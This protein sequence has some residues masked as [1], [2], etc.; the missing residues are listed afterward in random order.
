[1]T[2]THAKADEPSL[3][4]RTARG[5]SYLMVQ[6]A[7]SRVVMFVSQIFLG[8]ILFPEDFGLS[9]LAGTIS[10]VAWSI[11]GFGVDDVLLQRG[12]TMPKWE[13]TIFFLGVSIGTT[14]ALIVLALAPVIAWLYGHQEIMLLLCLSSL[15]LFIAG[16]ETVPMVKVRAAFDFKFLAGLNAFNVVLGQALAILFALSGFGPYSFFLPLPIQILVRVGLL[17]M[18]ARP[19][20]EGR[21]SWARA[22]LALSS[23]SKVL[24]VRFSDAVTGEAD[25]FVLGFFAATNI[26]G[27]YTFAFRLAAVP[28]RMMSQSLRGVLLPAMVRIR[29]DSDKSE[30]VGAQSAEMLAYLVTPFCLLQAAVA[31]PAILLVLG[32]KWRASIPILQVLSLGLPAQA[33]TEVAKSQLV[34]SGQFARAMR[35]ATL[36]LAAFIAACVAGAALG[37]SL[38]LASAVAVHSIIANTTIFALVSR[39]RGAERLRNIE[40]V[41]VRPVLMSVAAAG[42]A[43]AVDH[44]IAPHAGLI[45]RVLAGGLAMVGVFAALVALFGR[46][47]GR[48]LFELFGALAVRRRGKAGLEQPAMEGV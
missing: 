1:M 35:Y 30:R 26:V 5:V 44:A 40:R 39:A 6:A 19:R 23:G 31:E 34:A 10:A 47:V 42:A 41:F 48:Q 4:V 25:Y 21:F 11:I 37:S 43:L 8:W 14:V 13:R 12:R 45:V 16:F 18:R 46:R 36:S 24:G 38:G 32:E 22:R 15:S 29:R 27:F 9:A 7:A 28:V 3:R 20:L 17:W 33:V 2:E